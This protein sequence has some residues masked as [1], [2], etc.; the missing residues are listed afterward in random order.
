MTRD[1]RICF[2]GDSLVAGV[3]DP[4]CLGW[5][6]RLTARAFAAGQPVTPYNLGVR[7]QTSADILARWEEECARRLAEGTDRRVV[8]SLGVNDTTL[9]GGRPRV[10]PE[11]STA[12]LAKMLDGAAGRGWQALVVAPPPVADPGQNLRTARLDERF[13]SLCREAGVP[14]VAAHRPLS[15]NAVWM[16]EVRVGDGSHPG[17]AGYEEFAALLAPHWAAWLC[18]AEQRRPG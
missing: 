6:G 12:N 11:E 3:G 1:L 4:L 9:E 18:L 2:V 10:A 8:F 17:A 14:Y 16:H 13:A 7:R 15:G 5:P